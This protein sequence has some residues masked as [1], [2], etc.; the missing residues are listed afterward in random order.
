MGNKLPHIDIE[1]N[2]HLHRL[3]SYHII[4]RHIFLADAYAFKIYII[5]KLHRNARRYCP[6]INYSSI[7][8]SIL[9]YALFIWCETH[10]TFFTFYHIICR[11]ICC[12]VAYGFKIY[13]IE[14]LH[15]NARRY[16]PNINCSSLIKSTLQCALF[17]WG[18]THFTFFRYKGT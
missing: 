6:N 2:L 12:A 7:I 10:F 5:E 4:C 9:Q 3:I 8:K 18:E 14:K 15:R 13:I 11:D 16:C 1:T 17:I